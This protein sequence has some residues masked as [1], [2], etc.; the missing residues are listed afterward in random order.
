MEI[1]RKIGLNIKELRKLKGFSQEDFALKCGLDRTY[2]SGVE[3]GKRNVAIINLEK[4]LSN[5]DIS[6]SDFFKDM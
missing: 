6:F 5:L 2:I 3:N 1:L 4:I